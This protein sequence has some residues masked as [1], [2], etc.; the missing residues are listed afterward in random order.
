MRNEAT[1]LECLQTILEFACN[2]KYIQPIEC[3]HK[4]LQLKVTGV[5][6]YRQL[7]ARCNNYKV[8]KVPFKTAGDNI[9]N[10]IRDLLIYMQ[11]VNNKRNFE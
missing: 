2:V 5:A 7:Q 8:N 9:H 3:V 1:V 11:F 4:L 6:L 10:S